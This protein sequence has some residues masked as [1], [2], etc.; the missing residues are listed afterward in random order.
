M[1]RRIVLIVSLLGLLV[2]SCKKEE[3]PQ[4]L[5]VGTWEASASVSPQGN[6]AGAQEVT[7]IVFTFEANGKGSFA[8]A[9]VLDFTY[10]YVKENNTIRLQ[11]GIDNTLYIDSLNKDSFV[12]HST[13]PAQP[14]GTIGPMD[15][16]F[17]GKKIK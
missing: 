9:D 3:D 15:W 1:K 17:Y 10:Q 13:E 6:P 8:V 12:F 2:C 4:L 7:G 5:L 16:V 11:G 14:S